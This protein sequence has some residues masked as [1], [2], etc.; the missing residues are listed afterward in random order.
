MT[1]GA[2]TSAQQQPRGGGM[3]WEVGGR[4]KREG[5]DV[6]LCVIHIEK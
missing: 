6:Y 4:F 3:E 2:Q 1:Q 5:T